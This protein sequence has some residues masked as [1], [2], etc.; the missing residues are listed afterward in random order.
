MFWKMLTKSWDCKRP[1]PR[2][3]PH[4]SLVGT[5]TL[6][7]YEN[8]KWGAPLIKEEQRCKVYGLLSPY[9]NWGGANLEVES[10]AYSQQ[11]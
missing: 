7:L 9:F 8:P 6:L 5:K 11:S 1:S 2:P 4:Y 10:A 3:A